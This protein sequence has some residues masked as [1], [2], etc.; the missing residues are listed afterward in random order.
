MEPK[1][2]EQF[3]QKIQYLKTIMEAVAT[4]KVQIQEK[5][6]EYQQL[7]KEVNLGFELIQEAGFNLDNSNHFRSLF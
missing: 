5:D 6:E 3:L 1:I 4:G 7:Y 2:I